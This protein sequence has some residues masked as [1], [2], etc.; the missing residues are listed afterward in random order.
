M[1][2][3]LQTSWLSITLLCVLWP[4]LALGEPQSPARTWKFDLKTPG[5]YKLQI[6]HGVPEP[7][8]GQKVTYA[9]SIGTQT[10]NRTL[11]L[12]ANRPFVPLVVEVP[13]PERMQVV[14][15]GLSKTELQRTQVYAF[16]ADSLPAGEYFDPAKSTDFPEAKVI[17]A[18]LKQSPDGIDLA[19]AKLTIDK[20]IDAEINIAKELETIDA[21]VARVRQMPG[22]GLSSTSTM[23]AL[24]R[25]VYEPGMWNDFRPFEYDLDDPFGA[26]IAN[27]L[28]PTYLESRKGNCVTMPLLLV[29]VGQRLGIEITASTAPKHI[30]VKFKNEA[31][32]WINLEATSGANPARD[33]WVRQQ[34][35]MTD[36]ALA[37]GIYLQPL[38]NKQ[39][40]AVMATALIEHY[41]QQQEYGKAIT[42]A[43]LTLSHYPKDVSAMTMTGV[44]YGRL[45]RKHFQ[46]KYPSP[47]QIP[48][49][50]RGYFEYL[51]RNNR[52]WFAKAESLG[53]REETKKDAERYL[54]S[55]NAARK[56]VH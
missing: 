9:V 38:T 18:L 56:A 39:V 28:L 45:A 23:M 5:N 29:I 17:R 21:I 46:Q 48:A 40:L 11:D 33:I 52:L 4:L 41:L 54:Q 44:A 43:G 37:N 47:H 32:A 31:G 49:A 24:K 20:A 27:K 55:I 50:E 6:E 13:G 22:F 14:I 25:F 8:A 26:R 51:S 34:M 1:T 16:D 19:R 30:L 53:W 15:T 2:K 3:H 35:P 42:I 36:E 10:R 7:V 12:V